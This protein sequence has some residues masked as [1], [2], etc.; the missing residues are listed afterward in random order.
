MEG[1]KYARIF[2]GSTSR[3]QMEARPPKGGQQVLKGP[4]LWKNLSHRG[5][6][7]KRGKGQT[8]KKECGPSKLELDK[9][10]K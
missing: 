6:N 5:G 2:G 3:R 4:G 10:S 9:F 8:K 7:V 1:D